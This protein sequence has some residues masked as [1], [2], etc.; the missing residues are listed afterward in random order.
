MKIHRRIGINPEILEEII[1][2]PELRDK[3]IDHIGEYNQ[4]GDLTLEL[5]YV[6]KP[7]RPI[8]EQ[9][10]GIKVSDLECLD[11]YFIDT[12]GMKADTDF[13]G[14]SIAD[15]VYFYTD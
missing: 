4:Y 6:Y 15:R 7:N 10:F 8:H 12:L 5:T 2:D 14:D 11:K 3:V 13:I 1:K 9:A